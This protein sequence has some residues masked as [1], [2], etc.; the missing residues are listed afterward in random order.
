MLFMVLKV[1]Q[2][3]RLTLFVFQKQRPCYSALLI[4]HSVSL[5]VFTATISLVENLS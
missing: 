2:F 3:N 5:A 4:E 1:I